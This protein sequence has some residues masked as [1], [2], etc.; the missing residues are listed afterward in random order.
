MTDIW[1]I[2]PSVRSET[3]RLE[4]VLVHEPGAEF[5]TVVD[6]EEWNWDGLPRQKETAAEHRELVDVLESRGVIVHHL[7]DVRDN[8]AESLYVRDVG[9]AI[10]GGIVLGRMVKERRRGEE[11]QITERIVDLGMPI[12]HSV[13]GSGGFEA[14]N[15]VWLDEHTVA[16]GRSQTTNAAGI[17]QVRTVFQTFDV[18][19]IEVPIFGSTKSTGQTHLALVFSMVAPDLALVYPEAVPP[20]FLETLHDR[21]IETISVPMR[22][23]RNWATSTIVVEPGVIIIPAG[24]HKTIAELN[25]R[26]FEVI[27]LSVRN[28]GKAGGGPKGLVLP[29]SRASDSL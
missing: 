12:Y 26:R 22:E 5:S 24:N 16:I 28:I 29:L 7:Q 18:D 6:P 10:G 3:G 13:H 23:Q 11:R 1:D 20:E 14:G 25:S 15:L 21:G 27:E 17:D 4:R 8:L 2:S 19:V 9:F